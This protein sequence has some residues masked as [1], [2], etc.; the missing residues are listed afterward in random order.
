MKNELYTSR[1]L[2]ETLAEWNEHTNQNESINHTISYPQD[3][4]AL[5][6]V[7]VTSALATAAVTS[8]ALATV[9]VSSALATVVVTSTLATVTVASA[10]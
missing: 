5:A 2:G 6:T 8:T 1:I 9:A 3:S 10:L 7:V 4:L